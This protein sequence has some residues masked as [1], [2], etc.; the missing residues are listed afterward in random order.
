MGVVYKAVD[1][2]LH[3]FV[4]LKFLP[5]DVA[6]DAQALARFQ[7]EAQAASALNH[8]NICTIYDIGEEGGQA[9]IAMEF[10]DGLTLKH[11]IGGKPLEVDLLLSLAIEIADAL[12][13]AHTEGIVHRDIKP[14][15]VFVTKRDHAKILDFGLAKVT[16]VRD[17]LL[18]AVTAA[19]QEATIVEEH[20]TSPGTTL[21]TVAYMS[22]EQ[23]RAK[24]LDARSDL[25]SFG[26]VLYEMATGHMPFRG[27]STATIFDAI[28][29][30]APVPAI[31][32]NP[33]VP[34]KLEDVINKAL[35]KDRRLRYQH[36]SELHADLQ[37]LKRDTTSGPF[38]FAEEAEPASGHMRPAV[39]DSG[40]V[41]GRQSFWIAVLPFKGP[42]GD[43]ALEALT[44]GL[45]EDI[46]I[47]L[48]RFAYLQVVSHTSAM[49]YKGRSAR[50]R[51]VGQGLGARYLLE[52]SV[53]RAGSTVRISAQLVDTAVGAQLWAHAYD[54]ELSDASPFQIQDD[55]TDRVVA[56]V[57]DCEGVL[58]RSMAASIRERPV[59]ELS[60]SEWVLHCYSGFL[61][62][63]DPAEHALE[64]AGLES[65]LKRE[66]NHAEGWAA[67]SFLYSC[68][69]SLGMNPL[70]DSL[71][72]AQRAAQRAVDVGPASQSAW[73]SL[74]IAYFFRR[75]FTAF[76]V[77]AD[78]AVS[79][80]PRHCTLCAYMGSFILYTGEWERGYN[81]VQKMM[82]LNPH[83][84]GWLYLIPF[85]YHYRKNEYEK[86]LLAAKQINMP[87]YHWTYLVVAA[88]CGQLQ[89]KQEA[90]A[91]INTLRQHAPAFLDLTVVRED[92]EKWFADKEFVD[93]LLHGLVK[94]G[95]EFGA[96]ESPSQ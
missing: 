32:L 92:L 93:H 18:E 81:L 38:V 63:F 48:S 20:L 85:Y 82:S 51:T 91:A 2:R 45:C 41:Q 88:A 4:A 62:Q 68:E 37:R 50:L 16:P 84:S 9:F 89:R 69:R 36:A 12:D 34:P 27:E 42:G 95:L 96:P 73:F 54:R 61:Q 83:H 30:R 11:H 76:H 22:P 72:R 21:G 24:E 40:S 77:A 53:R 39:A 56:T 31:R 49:A 19:G 14:A 65:A 58:V 44:D 6:R 59:D 74:A 87:Q 55:I 60:A 25:F 10:L 57:A 1:A 33:D 15:N 71:E 47:G 29:N 43:A 70:P 86:A 23:A 35:E 13:A 3:R 46:T 79:L 64:R 80:N 67:L 94:A 7:R 26:A 8:P 78:R 5:D 90:T 28:L 52:G 75:D 17:R 66:P